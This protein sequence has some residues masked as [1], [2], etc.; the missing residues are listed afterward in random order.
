MTDFAKEVRELWTEAEEADRENRDE[1]LIDLEFAAGEQWDER[2]KNYR[3]SNKPFPLPCL[4]I[5][6]LPQFVGQVVGDR[7]ANQTS[8]KVLPRE[9]G[10]T[11]VAEVRSELIRS[12]EL[13]SKANRVYIQA[14]QQA[15]TCGIGNF[16]VDLDYADEDVFERDI[17]INGIANPLAVLW[18]PMA[19][20]PT[21]RDAEYCFVA[22]RIRRAEYKRRFGE[23]A[24]STLNEDP[25]FRDGGWVDSDTVRIAEWWRMTEKDKTVALTADGKTIDI[26]GKKPKDFQIV[27][28]PL[29]QQQVAT[30]GQ[31]KLFIHPS[32]GEPYIRETKCKY[33]TMVLTN[34]KEELADPFEAKL[35]RLPIIRVMGQEIWVGDRR[36]RFGLV[37]FARDMNR[38]EDYMYSVAAQKLMSAP[39]HDF[40]AQAK[41][42]KGRENDW[43]N[44]LIY[45]DD[46]QIPPQ[47]NTENNLQSLIAMAQIFSQKMKETTGIYEA[48]LGMRSNETSGIAIQRRQHEGDIATIG[49]HDNMDSAQQEAGEVCDAYIPIA[50]DTARTIRTVGMDDAIK[51]IRVNDPNDTESVDL[52]TGKYD[53]AVSTGPAYMTKRQ[54]AASSMIEFTRAMGPQFGMRVADLVA[55]AQ[56]WPKA[57]EFAKR[58]RP[59]DVAS[60][61]GEQDP[62]AMQRQ[63]EAQAMQRQAM[64]LE[65]QAKEA[66]TR[67][68]IAQAE[69]A[70][71]DAR[72]SAAEAE[73]AEAETQEIKAELL[74]KAASL[75]NAGNEDA[76][77]VE[78]A[79]NGPI[80]SFP[81][82]GPMS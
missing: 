49:F 50:Y 10:D 42:I 47:P 21:A 43:P 63:A 12:I 82:E 41:A 32:T 76:D 14:F 36:V 34:G 16:R 57:D 81:A 45:S 53:V 15:V 8:I 27:V 67:L 3:E 39:R 51:L 1:A 59:E 37:R 11:K 25:S 65:M 71:A 7:R 79:P 68:K 69:K 33:A 48:G 26:T 23:E 54:E 4:T 29:T 18:D 13:Q 9:S 44:T 75:A 70:E 22:D 31:V 20:D 17:F 28:D 2:V 80:H 55:G 74:L 52:V 30:D 6:T 60:E 78:T 61:D 62:E 77:Y 19:Q 40:I 72:K 38:L 73:K 66:D 5:N 24:S 46:A 64:T 58:L 35:P 56:D